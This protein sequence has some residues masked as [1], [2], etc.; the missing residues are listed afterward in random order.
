MYAI[1]LKT[2]SDKIN[3]EDISLIWD[4]PLILLKKARSI[5]NL[6]VLKRQG[7]RLHTRWEVDI[8][9]ASLYWYEDDVLEKETGTVKFYMQKGDFGN[10]WGY[11]RISPAQRAKAKIE[12]KA[13]CDWGIPVLE[14][15]VKKTLERK[16][17]VML[18]S[19][20]RAIKDTL[21]DNE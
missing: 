15:Y 19:L 14:P 1:E 17:K 3:P 21:E 4:N 7:N 12:L 2:Y 16:T 11:W 8:E 5:K 9:G 20:L 10:Y 13:N 6:R 18:K